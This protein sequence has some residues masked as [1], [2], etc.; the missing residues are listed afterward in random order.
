MRY[1]NRLFLYA[2]F[3]ILLIIAAAAMLRWWDVAHEW[4]TTLLAANRGKDIAPGVTLHFASKEIGGFPFNL[5]V[6]LGHM[7]LAVQSTRG[8]ISL[9][10]ERFAIHA[11]TYGRTQQIFEAA[12]TQT[13]SWA[14]VKGATRR[15]VF[16]PGSLRASA[17]EREGRLLRFDLDLNEFN[18]PALTGGR[19][20]FH[21]R[22]TPDHDALDVVVQADDLRGKSPDA[23]LPHVT[24]AGQIVPARILSSLLSAHDE[25]RRALAGWCTAG[26]A[27]QVDNLTIAWGDSHLT[28]KGTFTLDADHRVTG[29]ATMQL[30]GAGSWRPTH[31]VENRF[32]SSLEQAANAIPSK[33][34]SL[35][36][37]IRNGSVIVSSAAGRRYGGTIDPVF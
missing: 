35:S 16:V 33:P 12:G 14:D 32:T 22:R 29:G 28:G 15:F 31:L 21:I 20:Q 26:G 17:I 7:V 5:D 10:S 30:F 34:L 25:W 19:A 37:D 9:E 4:E 23:V 27:L 18:S 36:F 13:L 3:V 8:P 24:I 1:S 11:L 6:V 2:P